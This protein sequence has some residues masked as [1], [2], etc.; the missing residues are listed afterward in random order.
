M[1][2]MGSVVSGAWDLGVW[3]NRLDAMGGGIN[4]IDQYEVDFRC[5]LITAIYEAAASA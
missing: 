5:P 2:A 1:D 4:V 3:G